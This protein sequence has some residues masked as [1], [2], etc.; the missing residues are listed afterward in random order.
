MSKDPQLKA[1]YVEKFGTYAEEISALRAKLED[2]DQR[3]TLEEIANASERVKAFKK[4]KDGFERIKDIYG[5]EGGWRLQPE[6]RHRPRQEERRCDRLGP[7]RSFRFRWGA[8][9]GAADARHLACA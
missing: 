4:D 2:T 7:T 1:S 6:A 5:L 9:F 8:P 3:V